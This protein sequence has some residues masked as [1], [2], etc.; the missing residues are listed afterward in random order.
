MINH[1]GIGVDA[2]Q[3]QIMW[4]DRLQ[5]LWKFGTTANVKNLALE[6]W[7]LDQ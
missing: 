4:S 2:I 5:G 6:L 3:G 1:H 7:A